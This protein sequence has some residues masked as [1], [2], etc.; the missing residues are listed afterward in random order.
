[1]TALRDQSVDLTN[2]DREPIHKLGYVQPF[3]ALVALTSDWIVAHR[4]ANL[5]EVLQLDDKI[6]IGSGI[7]PRLSGEAFSIIR[8]RLD[9]A[10]ATGEVERI[11]GISL[12]DDQRQFDLAVHRSGRMAVLE[13]ERHDR[14]S[15]PQHTGMLRPIMARLR[16][17][18]TVDELCREAARHMKRL[19]GFDRVMVYR[20]HPD[21]SG[22]VIAEQREPELEAFLGLRYPKTDIP[23]QA[24]ALYLK[25]L[26]RIISDVNAEPVPVEPET[27]L[28]GEPLDLSMSVLRAVSPIH[29]EYLQNMGVEAS[30]SISIV[31]RGKLWGLFACH[32][33]SPRVLSYS[34]RTVAE[35]FS[36]LFS[37]QLEI[38]LANAGNLLAERGRELHDRLMARLAGSHSLAENLATLGEVIGDVIPHDGSSAYIEEVYKSRGLAPDETE[39]AAIVP[40]LNTGST[41]KILHSVSLA[42]LIPKA[43][44]FAE[45]VVGALVIPVSR[46]PRDY[47]VLWRKELPQVVTWAG[48]PEK[49]VEYG[50]HGSRLTPRKS[51]EAW[52]ESV[53]GQSSPWT[54]EELAVAEGLRVT[55][56]E[57]VLRVTDEAMQERTR[58]QQQQELLIAE[59]NHRVRNILT[60]IRGLVG[61]SKAGATDVES[62]ADVVG[63]RVRALALAHDN[64]TRQRWNASSFHDL[65]RNEAEAYLTGKEDRVQLEGPDAMVAPEAY[66][67]LALVIHEMMT[68]SAKYGSLCDQTGRLKIATEVG[69]KNELR[70]TWRETG[71]PP[72]Q[73]PSRKGFGSTIIERSIPYDLNGEAE[74]RYR[75]NG[76]EAD[77]L[78]P[79]R[80][81]EK[82]MERDVTA[83]SPSAPDKGEHRSAPETIRTVLLLED[84]MLIA[85]DAEDALNQAGIRKVLIASNTE[86][87]LAQIER[88]KPDFALLDFN[89][90]DETSERVA[91]AL[92]EAGIPFCYATGYGEAMESLAVRPPCGVLKK[93]YSQDE[94][95]EMLTK[96]AE[97]CE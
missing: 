13:I 48:N 50:P 12:F 39:F 89:L 1:M 51:F 27:D 61:Q 76:V 34:L 22:E 74:V 32:H 72:V 45:K 69:E 10:A 97:G 38:A 82:T 73:A 42:D 36:Q 63:G 91:D 56:L 79:G 80:F 49:P 52:Q 87:A 28:E 4:S 92:A 75:L 23:K 3:G 16:D 33:Y 81:V 20:F 17:C 90:G 57:V 55:L 64:I 8:E 37:L 86:A 83:P 19:L 68:N 5:E 7:A 95:V 35:L 78:I 14:G 58:A 21:L 71:G 46:R 53:K 54:E 24:R 60:L 40:A 41:S 77:F 2:C 67:V 70:I 66:T 26:F 30:L 94:I 93:P 47:V 62:F 85:L 18:R 44:D 88:E 6:E 43:S 11:F 96:A 59:L 65:V 15:I 29:I 84:N 31:V 9:A 25:N